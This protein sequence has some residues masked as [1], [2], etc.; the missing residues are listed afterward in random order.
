MKYL[1]ANVKITTLNGEWMND[2]FTNDNGNVV[3]KETFKEKDTGN[4]INTDITAK[5]FKSNQSN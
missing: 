4:P 1:M 5:A 3:F 2:W